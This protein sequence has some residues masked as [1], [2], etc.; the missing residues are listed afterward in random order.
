MLT[1]TPA[2]HQAA[3]YLTDDQAEAYDQGY[4]DGWEDALDAITAAVDDERRRGT[5]AP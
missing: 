5:V 3:G 1:R 4:A 2:G